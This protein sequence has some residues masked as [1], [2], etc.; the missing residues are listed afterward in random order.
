[1]YMHVCMHVDVSCLTAQCQHNDTDGSEQPE[2]N[3]W[4]HQ[5]SE[6]LSVL[7]T[8]HLVLCSVGNQ[9]GV[10]KESGESHPRSVMWCIN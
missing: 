2:P 9:I 6:L 1:M 7:R 5:M 10:G 3:N 4:F 8:A